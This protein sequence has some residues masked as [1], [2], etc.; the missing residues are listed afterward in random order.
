MTA[1]LSIE[2]FWSKIIGYS[3]DDLYQP[4]EAEEEGVVDVQLQP[5]RSG[6]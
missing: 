4:A 3:S 2:V 1:Y 6:R 5:L